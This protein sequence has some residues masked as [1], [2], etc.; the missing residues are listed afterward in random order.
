MLW[1]VDVTHGSPL[2]APLRPSLLSCTLLLISNSS[3]PLEP[4]NYWPFLQCG[5]RHD[6]GGTDGWG[7]PVPVPRSTLIWVSD[8]WIL[9]LLKAY[10]AV[11]FFRETKPLLRGKKGVASSSSSA[12][13]KE[14]GKHLVVKPVDQQNCE[15]NCH[16]QGDRS[17][18]AQEFF[19]RLLLTEKLVQ[20]A[21]ISTILHLSF[22]ASCKLACL[23]RV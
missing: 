11:F 4:S 23:S 9:G 1:N 2:S 16:V 13:K 12:R 7:V 3:T 22:E 15:I 21:I 20:F 10:L 8:W 18:Q 5:H 14:A 17:A 19:H 6:G